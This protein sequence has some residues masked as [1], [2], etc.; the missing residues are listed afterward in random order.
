M[1][2][3]HHARARG[4]TLA[5]VT[6]TQVAVAGL[7]LGACSA[8]STTVPNTPA[9]EIVAPT[10]QSSTSAPPPAGTT[11]TTPPPSTSP[12]ATTT[13]GRTTTSGSLAQCRAADLDLSAGVEPGSA[14]MN[15][16]VVVI[17]ATNKS[18]QACALTGFPGVSMV[19]SASGNPQLG[20]SATRTSDPVTPVTLAPGG[21]STATV[22]MTRPD[23]YPECTPTP[24]QGLRVY[25]PDATDSTVLSVANGNLSGCA[26]SLT[27]TLMTVSPFRPG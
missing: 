16:Y 11:G 24:A 19:T 2:I 17:G 13:A 15:H 23:P 8:R 27:V 9:P 26:G 7:A 14:G 10:T 22:S 5:I 21:Q 4:R 12:P 25:L 20:R 6:L 3:Q 18:G 1:S